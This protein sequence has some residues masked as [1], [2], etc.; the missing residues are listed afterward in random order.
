M[1]SIKLMLSMM[2]A[3][4][5]AF[6]QEATPQPAS[7]VTAEAE[8]QTG[9]AS[10]AAPAAAA[11]TPVSLTIQDQRDP[12]ETK[13]KILSLMITSC[14]YG[15]YRLGEKKAPGRFE[16]L[17]K[18][19]LE[20][21]GAALAGKSFTISRYN[22]YFNNAIPLR[23][24]TFS[25][26]GGALFDMLKEKGVNCPKEKT[27]P[28]WFEL[29]EVTGP[30]SPLIVDFDA[31]LDGIAHHVRVVHT[32]SLAM[33]GSFKEPQEVAELTAT[34]RKVAEDLAAQLP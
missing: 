34:M 14:D 11:V 24:M 33:F 8:A 15:V 9:T 7:P 25:Q 1:K 32:P 27:G 23:G 6:A 20:L 22:I 5:T 30:F 12:K 3:A 10:E 19:L 18:D 4:A 2:L 28:G 31:S 16:A 26:F 29:S 21:K 17:R 13:Q